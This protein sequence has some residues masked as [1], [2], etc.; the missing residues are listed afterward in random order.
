MSKL[1]ADTRAQSD[2]D[3]LHRLLRFITGDRGDHVF[4]RDM[5]MNYYRD[6]SVLVK[7][8]GALGALIDHPF[9]ITTEYDGK[10]YVVGVGACPYFNMQIVKTGSGDKAAAALRSLLE[11]VYRLAVD[12][13]V[14]SC[15][16]EDFFVRVL[17]PNDSIY[18]PDIKD[19]MPCACTIL[20]IQGCYDFNYC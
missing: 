18:A 5:R 19:G 3:C 6:L 13:G 2:R 1:S 17:G 8:Y 11:T 10:E 12:E 14:E 7:R 9:L 15:D 16:H 4:S 20:L